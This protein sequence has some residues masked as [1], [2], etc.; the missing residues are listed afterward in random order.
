MPRRSIEETPATHHFNF[1]YGAYRLSQWHIPYFASTLSIP[2]AANDLQLTSEIPGAEE[3]NWEIDELYQRDID[4]PRVERQ[5]V[6]YLDRE[7]TPQF[8]NSLTIALVPFDPRGQ[9]VLSSFRADHDWNPPGLTDPGRFEVTTNVGPLSLG[10]WEE[11]ESFSDPKFQSGVLRWNTDEVVGVAIDG[12][13]RLAALK[14]INK[15]GDASLRDTRVPV[16]FILFDERVGF[17]GPEPRSVIQL[18]R[19]LFID[20]NK[21]AQTVTRARQ[22]L[23][24][25]RD[26]HARCVRK[27]VGRQLDKHTDELNLSPPRLP[28]SLV[29][30]H[31]E[32]ARFD[33]GPYIGTVL[34]MDWVVSRVLD[35]SPVADFTNYGGVKRQLRQLQRQLG[36]DLSDAWTRVENLDSVRL[37]PF[38]YSDDELGAIEQNF[39]YIWATPIC[40][41]LTNFAPYA[42][43]LNMR[44]NDYSL[45]LEF[46]H[47]FRLYERMQNDPYSGKATDEYNQFIGRM[48]QRQDS[49]RDENY[50]LDKLEN[51]NEFKNGKLAFNVVFQRALVEGYIEYAKIDDTAITE[52]EEQQGN[53]TDLTDLDV[54]FDL[55]EVDEEYEELTSYDVEDSTA[56]SEVEQ[57]SDR[58]K[59]RAEEYTNSLNRLVHAWPEVLSVD[60]TYASSEEESGFFWLGTLRKPEGGIDF[61]QGASKRAKD[62]LFMAA[63]ACL[64]SDTIES[65]DVLDFEEFWS[66]TLEGSGPAVINKFGR[67]VNRFSNGA[68]T[69]GGRIVRARDDEYGYDQSLEE[70]YWRARW[71]WEVLEL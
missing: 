33:D 14:A 22:I 38:G 63:A 11:W 3:I 67:S 57:R 62:L 36:V 32:Q 24:D 70:A 60:A 4:W 18:L 51:H 49:P 39:A 15:R 27:L 53:S 26:P 43:F 8:F 9:E 35:S 71:L 37:T 20:L 56:D 23:L 40:K 59:R 41:L 2:E 68:K 17:A 6:P 34:G 64:Y 52:L 50:F 54:D 12:Q 61:T 30:W 29:D 69:A 16:I 28:L 21:H 42:Q 7:N 1:L 45:S 44:L 65:D 48:R 47:W 19:N 55:D 13:H 46:Q 5:I 10:F 58:A 66:M 31:R 25:D